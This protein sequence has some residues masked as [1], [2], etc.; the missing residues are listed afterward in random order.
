[1]GPGRLH[2]RG[3]TY[4]DGLPP[5]IEIAYKQPVSRLGMTPTEILGHG[6]ERYGHQRLPGHLELTPNVSQPCG[7]LKLEGTPD[8]KVAPKLARHMIDP[9]DYNLERLKGRA[10]KEYLRNTSGIPPE[11]LRNTSGI[12]I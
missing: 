6:C 2:L 3:I 10:A 12:P 7:L 5:V 11:Y 4:T 1:M 8:I 9:E